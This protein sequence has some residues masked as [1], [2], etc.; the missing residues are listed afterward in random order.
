MGYIYRYWHYYRNEKSWNI[1]RTAD[2]RTMKQSYLMFHTLS[3]E[4]AIGDLIEMA[5]QR[6]RK[7]R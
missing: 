2:Y 4:L 1:Y 7:R 3:P 6:K 5:E